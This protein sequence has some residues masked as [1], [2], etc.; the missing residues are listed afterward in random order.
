MTTSRSIRTIS[1]P[2]DFIKRAQMAVKEN[3]RSGDT[4][5]IAKAVLEAAIRTD[6]DLSDLH[7]ENKSPR[8]IA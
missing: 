3:W 8:S 1:F 7:D 6:R 2:Q 5:V 4:I